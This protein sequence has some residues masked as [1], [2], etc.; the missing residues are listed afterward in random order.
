MRPMTSEHTPHPVKVSYLETDLLS[1]VVSLLMRNYDISAFC[2]ERRMYIIR[3]E[4]WVSGK[5]NGV[6]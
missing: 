6:V 4:I 2:C 5:A 1:L 3:V